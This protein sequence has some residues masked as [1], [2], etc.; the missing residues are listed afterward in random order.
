MLKVYKAVVL[1]ELLYSCGTWTVYQ[2]HAKRLNHFHTSCLK[3]LLKIKWQDRIPDT[4]VL[5]RAGMHCTYSSE[6]G[7]V[8]MDRQCYQDA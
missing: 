8:K 2:W 4:E 1:P 5:K 3:K 7:T 6:T